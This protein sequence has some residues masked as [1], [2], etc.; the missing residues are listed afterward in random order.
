MADDRGELGLI[1]ALL[2]G[3]MVGGCLGLLFAPQTGAKTRKQVKKWIDEALET[4]EEKFEDVKEKVEEKFGHTQEVGREHEKK[5]AG[6]R[7]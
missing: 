1:F 4:A 2:T 5:T 6:S 3:A 7:T